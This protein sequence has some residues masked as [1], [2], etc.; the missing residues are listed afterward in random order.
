[1]KRSLR[2]SLLLAV[3]AVLALSLAARIA[4][5]DAAETPVPGEREE[6]L[7]VHISD[8]DTITVMRDDGLE[9]RVRLIGTGAPETHDSDIG[10]D[11]LG[12]EATDYIKTL[13]TEGETII[14]EKDVSEID[15][16][17]RLLR[18]VF[19]VGEDGEEIF[20][21]AE[22][23]RAGYAQAKFYDPDVKYKF[24]F[25]ALEREAQEAQLNL[26]GPQPTS[27][28]VEPVAEADDRVWVAGE[29]GELV[30]LRYD[31]DQGGPVMWF[32][33]GVEV[34]IRDVFWMP[35]SG[36][37]WYWL[38]LEDFR[39]WVEADAFVLGEP[40]NVLPGPVPRLAAY[41]NAYIVGDGPLDVYAAVGDA[42]PLGRLEQGARPQVQRITYAFETGAW[43]YWIDTQTLD[44][45]VE[46]A[47]LSRDDPADN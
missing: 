28:A 18:Y 30:P 37:Y 42:E 17:G 26:W 9:Y 14:L 8:G 47:R 13:L 1:M 3:A 15:R 19:A 23:I 43:W 41:D 31:A 24:Y 16:Y 40:D 11:Y 4:D 25:Y 10:A 46:G 45:W 34:V 36:S 6:A 32:P 20:V 27:P 35:S 2:L 38:E 12:Y 44:G 5:Q 29:A 22:M 21:N 33:V 39:G 7:L